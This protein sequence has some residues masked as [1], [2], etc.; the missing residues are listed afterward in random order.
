MYIRIRETNPATFSH[1]LIEAVKEAG[2]KG[3]VHLSGGVF[4]TLFAVYLP[5]IQV[6]IRGSGRGKTTIRLV[7]N[8][9]ASKEGRP[10]LIN[11]GANGTIFEH[12]RVNTSNAMRFR[13]GSCAINTNNCSD[14]QVL[15][16]EILNSGIGVGTADNQ[17]GKIPHGLICHRV[18]FRN[19]KHG[20]FFNRVMSK[21]DATYVKRMRITHCSFLG[22][23]EAGISIDCGN[24]GLDGQ[25][26]LGNLRSEWGMN[27]VTNMDD[28]EISNCEFGVAEKYNL[29]LAKVWNV[30]V[31]NNKFKGARELHGE[32]INIEHEAYDI[33]IENNLFTGRSHG[34]SQSHISILTFRDY[35]DSRKAYFGVD[36]SKFYAA[37][38]CSNI[39]IRRNSFKGDVANYVIAEYACKISIYGNYTKPFVDPKKKYSFWTGCSQIT[40]E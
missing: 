5:K 23:Q 2:H 29:A 9:R 13:E 30:N 22:K 1:R 27:T 35:Q 10:G 19:C 7:P 20:I 36:P 28:M 17:E 24:D 34:V 33:L 32:S 3:V 14:V 4:N 6:T 16:C 25:P 15:N 18:L 12:L 37:D 8:S 31:F 40:I 38:G 26:N 39:T 11:V 21:N